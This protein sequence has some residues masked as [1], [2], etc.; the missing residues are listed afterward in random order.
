AWLMDVGLGYGLLGVGFLTLAMQ[1]VRYF[2]D[3]K[4]EGFWIVVGIAFV[5]GA[6]WELWSVAIPLVPVVLIAV[7]VALLLWRVTRP[8]KKH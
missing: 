1:L 4:V 6:F 5:I 3:V 8:E 2:A 7:G